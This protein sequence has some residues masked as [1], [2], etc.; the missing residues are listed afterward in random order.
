MGAATV[1]D[2]GRRVRPL[3][4]LLGL[5]AIALGAAP[6]AAQGATAPAE[7]EK[8]PP[9]RFT[10]STELSLVVTSG[11]SEVQT[12]GLKN[13]LEYRA[14]KGR[15]RFRIDAFRS[16]T[17]DDP[18]LLVEPGI[19]FEPGETPTGFS[20]LEV[21]PGAEP[22]AERFFAEGRY[23]G[24]LPRKATW[25]A[26]ASWDRNE[27]AGIL[28]RTI[29]FGG[30][31]NAWVERE[32]RAF[33]STYGVSYTDRLEEVEDPEKDRRFP[34]ARLTLD[35]MDK[36][37]ASTTYDADLTYNINLSDVSDYY[38]DFVQGLAVNMTS[39]LALKISLQLTYSSEPALEEVDVI[40][41][42]RLVDPDGIPGNGD[43]FFE[44]VESGG[45]EITVGEDTIR[46]ESLDTTF[47][48]S[49]QITY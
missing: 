22:D 30:L 20:T 47:R 28:R 46:K 12:F 43:E 32:D 11:N 5:V 23:D 34:G 15:A 49:L 1:R 33:R 38:A 2:S 7:G 10:N 36:W 42:F 18:F 16:D 40:V 13:T 25:N 21:R 41:R 35:F 9:P 48:T 44:T 27:D 8:K 14:A 19:T 3:G 45:G 26:G 31:G 29:V 37:G 17:S 39:H 6:A 4:L 24:D